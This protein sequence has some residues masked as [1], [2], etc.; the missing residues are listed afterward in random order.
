MKFNL[1]LLS[2]TSRKACI[3]IS[4]LSGAAF[5]SSCTHN[6]PEPIPDRAAFTVINAAPS[7]P[8]VDFYLN[9]TILPINTPLVYG[10]NTKYFVVIPPGSK[11]GKVTVAGNT[12]NIGTQK[13][14]LE[15]DRYHSVF[16]TN[17]A[18]TVSL[19]KIRDDWGND[20]A[21]SAQV[22]FV[23]LS[24]DAPNY[25]LEYANDPTTFSNR[26]YREYTEFKYVPAKTGITLNL[27]NTATN[28][29]VATLADIELK[30]RVIYTV[31]AKGFAN[32]LPT[33][34]ARRIKITRHD[35]RIY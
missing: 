27:R 3:F 6:D 33:D 31:W 22:R 20:K 26:A 18:D 16:I 35:P 24:P 5:I 9:N 34:T 15:N 25:S 8:S 14:D 21:G 2:E 7:R 10:N 4:L 19:L 11:T 17:S 23:N 13:I 1:T 32:Q 30:D 29:I 12:A 28:T